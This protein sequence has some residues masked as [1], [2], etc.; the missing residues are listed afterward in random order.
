[1]KTA[2]ALLTV[3]ALLTPQFASAQQRYD[4]RGYES[5]YM[6]T[7]PVYGRWHD[8]LAFPRTDHSYP[9]TENAGP[10]TATGGPSGGIN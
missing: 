1:M 10:S 2:F 9:M 6:S 5:V 8:R 4:P 3:A 7:A